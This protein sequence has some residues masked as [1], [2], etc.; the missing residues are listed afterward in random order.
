[1]GHC[2]RHHAILTSAA[3]HAVYDEIS[4]RSRKRHIDIVITR[5]CHDAART[6]RCSSQ[7]CTSQRNKLT[8]CYPFG[9][10]GSL[11]L[12]ASD[13]LRCSPTYCKGDLSAA[14]SLHTALTLCLP[15]RFEQFPWG[16]GIS[17]SITSRPP[18]RHTHARQNIW[19]KRLGSMG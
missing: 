10:F 9:F 5:E 11:T 18:Y 15:F 19:V 17:K 3:S 2:A 4:T 6:Q 8:A 7:Q 13:S 12:R 1:M 16:K 14:R